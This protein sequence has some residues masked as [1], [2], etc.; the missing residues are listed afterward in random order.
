MRILILGNSDTAGLR[1]ERGERAWPDLLRELRPADTVEAI[2][3]VPMGGAVAYV[4]GKAAEL[5]PDFVV[6]PLAVYVCAVGLVSESVGRRFGRRARS[7]YLRMERR[8]DGATRR[9]GEPGRLNRAGQAAARRLLG[10]APLAPAESVVAVYSGLLHEL[11][12]R[13]GT[14]VV[15]MGDGHFGRE[16]QRQNPSLPAVIARV[17][18]AIRPVVE[19]H[20]FSWIDAEAAMAATGRRHESMHDD[21]VHLSAEGHRIVA[22]LVHAA[23]PASDSRTRPSPTSGSAGGQ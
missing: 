12:R 7:A 22:A 17:Q 9:K 16:I 14:Q 11:A 15:V 20:H 8:Y 13:E 4:G 5:E 23:L 6:I 21:G 2:R 10:T 1:L 3:F 18:A 19:R